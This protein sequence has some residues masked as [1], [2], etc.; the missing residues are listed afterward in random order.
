MWRSW[1]FFRQ[2]KLNLIRLLRLHNAPDEIA[3]G[4][5]LG[6]FIGM[7]PTMSFQMP[8]AFVIA[9]LLNE[10]KIAAMVGVWITNPLTAP[11]IY[12]M[13][14]ETGRLLLGRPHPLLP[15]ELTWQGLLH[16]GWDFALPLLLGS[17]VFAVL[18]AAVTYPLALRFV[19]MMQRWRIPR[20]PRRKLSA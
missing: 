20:W 17:A 15:L 14:Y 7:T 3:R 5:A 11:F 9:L 10:S 4:L 13:E 16:L 6:I 8:L 1:G 2:A 19:P 12:A 18:C